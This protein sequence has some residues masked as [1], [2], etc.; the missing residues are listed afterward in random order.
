M[1]QS[2]LM[3]AK[4][5]KNDVKAESQV[6]DKKAASAVYL[7]KDIK[8]L[9]NKPIAELNK[10]SVKAYE[11]ESIKSNNSLFA[12]ICDNALT[13]R[14]ISSAKYNNIK[15]LSIVK[16]QASGKIIWPN[17]LEEKFCFVYEYT[18]GKPFL[19]SANATPA[20]KKKPED[21]INTVV[22]PLIDLLEEMANKDIVHGEIWPGNI[23]H[24]GAGAGDKAVLGE[25]LCMPAS[26]NLPM[27]YEPV[28]RALADPVGKGTGSLADDIYSL[29][30][31]LAVILRGHVPEKGMTDEEIIEEKIEK[32]SYT[33][34]LKN[35]RFS[36]A[37]LELLRGLLYDNP[38]QRWTLED[39]RAWQDGRRL[40]PKQSSPKIKATRP[41]IMGNKKYSRPELLAKDFVGNTIEAA[42]I[43]END[44][45]MQW[46]DRA[47]E[48]KSL[49]G[50]LQGIIK[51]SNNIDNGNDFHHR[52]S[53]AVSSVMFP[54]IPV[55]Y[56]DLRFHPRAF[57]KY[58]TKAYVEEKSMQHYTE[59]IRSYFTIF[60]LRAQ[61]KH[62]TS[63]LNSKFDVARNFIKSEKISMGLER[64]LYLLNPECQCL[65]PII[66]GYYAV[67]P[68]ELMDS[69]ESVCARDQQ[70]KELFDRH[71]IS[72]LVSRS[73]NNIE[74]Y[75]TD[76]TSD[77]PHKQ[78]L[79]KLRVLATIQKRLRLSN[80]P[81]IA[82]WLYNNL[83]PV[84]VRF[85]DD[86]KRVQIKEEL[87]RIK[88]KGDLVEVANLFDNK[89]IFDHDLTEFYDAMRTYEGVD[90][91]KERI[92]VRIKNKKIFGLKTGAQ[93]ASLISLVLAA[94]IIILV[95]YVKILKDFI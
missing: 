73:K 57:G 38:Q 56:K 32:G 15:S 40:S 87:K 1:L 59:V 3:N 27:L 47:I 17:P 25:C 31:S 54:D 4:N 86:N 26:T 19:E 75:L 13:P 36:G 46:I 33:T 70:P 81:N 65:S 35:D 30:V 14:R 94:A 42:K 82:N 34:L 84:L 62:D 64:C 28:E 92:I 91:E 44:D 20:L 69:L 50:R 76:I 41:V 39:I 53:V 5:S 37:T 67:N 93:V 49:K 9:T 60:V 89:F 61:K 29:G 48:D 10:G 52:L 72:F 90:K 18:M 66:K 51:E 16:Y 23:Y 88:S 79:G 83:D 55:M 95:S 11:A 63:A 74:P 7:N 68:E 45:L 24:G 12:L 6:S 21:V 43:I 77:Q 58:L 71:V 8:V 2:K 85:H 22:N 80:Y 78:F